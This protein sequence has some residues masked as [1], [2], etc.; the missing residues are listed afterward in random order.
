LPDFSGATRQT[1]QRLR[2]LGCLRESTRPP[3][4][5]A[6][7]LLK[8]HLLRHGDG[9]GFVCLCGSPAVSEDPI[10]PLAAQCVNVRL[11]S[12]EKT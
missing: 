4:P 9:C 3:L 1:S 10:S 7:V 6:A 11:E 2:R 12:I 5:A 8:G